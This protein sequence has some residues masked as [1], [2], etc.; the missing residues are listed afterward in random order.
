MVLKKQN[1]YF[2]QL[3]DVSGKD[4]AATS[5]SPSVAIG[6]IGGSGTRLI[7][8]LLKNTGI[9]MGFDL[10]AS[11]DDLLFSLFFR[12]P[13]LFD[14]GQIAFEK[15][16]RLYIQLRT[17]GL[18]GITQRD[19]AFLKNLIADSMPQLNFTWRQKRIVRVTNF[20]ESSSTSNIWGWKEPNTH[21]F[22]RSILLT[23]PAL[24]YIHVMRNGLDMAYSENQ[25]QLDLWGPA[26]L[27][28]NCESTPRNS[29]KYWKK[30][31]ENIL[32]LHLESPR[33]IYLLNFDNMCESFDIE[34]RKL[35]KFLDMP[36]DEKSVQQLSD[37][38]LIPE[39]SGRHKHYP[40]SE[41]DQ[42]DIEF[43]KNAGF[44]V[45]SIY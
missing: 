33:S 24:K 22:I 37:L 6:G 3:D 20:E 43:V 9:N 38:V 16:Y 12:R 17:R 28:S 26:V 41:F 27:A 10:N 5:I 1:Q 4:I 23:T 45:A 40:L 44:N 34:I 11:N 18:K 29:L 13:K 36:I 30:V 31:H 14:I 2:P 15:R 39:S 32:D 42:N 7:M 35:F 19:N 21:I 8:Q 25:N